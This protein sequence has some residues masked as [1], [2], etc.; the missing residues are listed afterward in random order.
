MRV[1]TKYQ[2]KKAA[3]TVPMKSISLATAVNRIVRRN[4]ETK[5]YQKTTKGIPVFSTNA[6]VWTQYFDPFA[7]IAIGT[8]NGQRVGDEIYVTKIVVMFGYQSG[9]NACYTDAKFKGRLVSAANFSSF[10]NNE[11]AVYTG[12]KPCWSNPPGTSGPSAPGL[13]MEQIDGIENSEQMKFHGSKGHIVRSHQYA[14]GGS[15]ITGFAFGSQ[16]STW[17]HTINLNRKIV[18]EKSTNAEGPSITSFI[19]LVHGIIAKA[20]NISSVGD[21]ELVCSYAVFYKDA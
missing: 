13:Q 6:L 18:F 2:L 11:L 10:N 7:G 3:A 14:V 12:Q 9:E 16:L 8:N 20:N 21:N 19:Y 5:I 17:K 15:A 1:P 4:M